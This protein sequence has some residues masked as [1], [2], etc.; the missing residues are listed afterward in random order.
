MQIG[1]FNQFDIFNKTVKP[2]SSLSISRRRK[3]NGDG[4]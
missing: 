4:D 3:M 2:S 1:K